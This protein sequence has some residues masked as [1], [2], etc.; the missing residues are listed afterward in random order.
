MDKEENQKNTSENHNQDTVNKTKKPEGYS[1]DKNKHETDQEPKEEIKEQT[2]EEK[3]DE[4]ISFIKL[5]IKKRNQVFWVCPLIEESKKVD[6]Q[7]SVKRY[8][9]LKKLHLDK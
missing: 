8:E 9:N 3:I 6:H 2:P 5:Q 7:S 1:G 4:I